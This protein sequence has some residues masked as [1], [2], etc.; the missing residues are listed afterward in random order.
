MQVVH[1]TLVLEVEDIMVEEQDLLMDMAV[2]GLLILEELLE[3]AQ[4]QE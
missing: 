4:H 2:V 1:Y 3:V